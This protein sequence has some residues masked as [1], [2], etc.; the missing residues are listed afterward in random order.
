MLTS[1]KKA[2]WGAELGLAA[3]TDVG[4]LSLLRAVH[5]GLRCWCV[6]AGV[7]CC[8]AREGGTAVECLRALAHDVVQ[9]PAGQ[10]TKG[11]CEATWQTWQERNSGCLDKHAHMT[12]PGF[13][14]GYPPLQVVPCQLG[15]GVSAGGTSKDGWKVT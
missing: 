15:H 6:A 11:G 14:P 10:K 12:P 8:R 3:G 13:E 9:Q 1:E 5:C 4:W 2:A 7:H